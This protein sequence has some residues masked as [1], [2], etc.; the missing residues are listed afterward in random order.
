MSNFEQPVSDKSG[1]G[2]MGGYKEGNGPK[3]SKCQSRDV[4]AIWRDAIWDETGC[5]CKACGNEFIKI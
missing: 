1:K 4:E 3:C 5:R 2:V